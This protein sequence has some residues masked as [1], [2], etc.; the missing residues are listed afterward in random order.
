MYNY[1]IKELKTSVRQT[2]VT[3]ETYGVLPRKTSICA[4]PI[5][6]NAMYY[7]PG[8]AHVR[9]P[10]VGRMLT[11]HVRDNGILIGEFVCARNYT[12]PAEIT[13]IVEDQDGGNHD[14][15]T[16]MTCLA[17]PEEE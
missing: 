1:V 14:G 4:M 9:P 17:D 2:G 3:A 8:V 16:S 5:P 12:G 11:M 7:E 15:S 13:V 6:H 10:G